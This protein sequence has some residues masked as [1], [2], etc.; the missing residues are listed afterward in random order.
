MQCKNAAKLA[1]DKTQFSDFFTS[2]ITRDDSTQRSEQIKNSLDLLSLSPQH[3]LVV[4]DRI[5][6]VHSAI[7]VG[8]SAILFNAE[9]QHS[10]KESKVISN[11]SELKKIVH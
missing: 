3:V 7:Q 2:I 10:F 11:L 6:D 9:K 4:G 8:C 1:L 5:H